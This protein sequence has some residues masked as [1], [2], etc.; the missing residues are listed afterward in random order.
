[1]GDKHTDE[2]KKAFEDSRPIQISED[3]LS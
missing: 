2:E 3:Y 1:M